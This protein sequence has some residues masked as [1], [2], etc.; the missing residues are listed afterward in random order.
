MNFNPR[1]P[2][3]DNRPDGLLESDMDFVRNNFELAVQLLEKLPE[4]LD[5]DGLSA[6]DR[7]EMIYEIFEGEPA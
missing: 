5:A 6:Q 1:R 2:F 3:E 4:I 7:I